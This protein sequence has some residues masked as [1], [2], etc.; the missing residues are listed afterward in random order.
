MGG[1]V[2]IR[3]K[4][5]LSEES[6]MVCTSC[7]VDYPSTAKFCTRCGK[8][9]VKRSSRVEANMTAKGL[10]SISI[11]TP[12]GTTFNSKGTVS[13]PLGKGISFQTSLRK[14]KP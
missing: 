12:D 2:R 9:L 11:K 4:V 14:G 13:K 1:G 3:Q 10:T 6:K 7:N 5:L 8:K